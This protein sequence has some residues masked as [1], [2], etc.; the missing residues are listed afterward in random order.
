[1]HYPLTNLSIPPSPNIHYPYSKPFTT[2]SLLR[3]QT[4]ILTL[5]EV[6][7]VQLTLYNPI[8]S[9]LTLKEAKLLW[10]F[11]GQDDKNVTNDHLPSSKVF[12]LYNFP[13]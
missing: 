12:S 6:V 1:M 9:P 3:H 2:R 7:K 11:T 5:S 10:S 8:G 4:V 13:Y